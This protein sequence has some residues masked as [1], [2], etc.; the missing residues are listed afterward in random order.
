VV[1]EEQ[2]VHRV[3]RHQVAG[4]VVQQHPRHQAAAAG[5]DGPE[6]GVAG[7][8]AHGGRLVRPPLANHRVARVRAG[9]RPA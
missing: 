9:R 2:G 7:E 6:S 1:D 4:G 3:E 8:V 5:N